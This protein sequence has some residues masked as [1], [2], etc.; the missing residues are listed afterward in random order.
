M[1]DFNLKTTT[2]I[3]I[4]ARHVYIAQL[5]GTIVGTYLSKFS[6]TEIQNA[7]QADESAVKESTALA[8][9]RALQGYKISPKHLYTAFPGKDVLIRHFQIPKIPRGEWD[10][11]IKFEAKK[12]IPF[13]I[14]ELLW[15]YHVVLHKSKDAKMDVTFVAVKNVVAQRYLS[16]FEQAG[17]KPAVLEPA[18]FSL[19]RLLTLSNQLEKDK[20]TMIVDVDYGLTDINIV[21]DKICYLTRDATL[22]LL[23]EELIFDA[24]LNEIRMSLDYYEKLFPGET[25]NKILLCGEVDLKDWDRRLAEESQ[26]T[27][28]KVNFTKAV[29]LK[30]AA[31]PL[32]MSVAIGLILR[33]LSVGLAEV[34][35]LQDRAVKPKPMMI[36]KEAI[37]LTPKSRQAILRAV[38]FSCIGLLILH[39][40]MF[41]LIGQ[42]KKKL[43]SLI[44]LR[45]QI[46]LPLGSVDYEKLKDIRQD[47]QNRLSPL[48]LIIDKR[49]FWTDKFNEIPKEIP[50]GVWLTNLFFSDEVAKKNKVERS[51]IIEGIAYH[52]DPVQEIGIV[53]KFVSDLKENEIFFQGLEEIKLD[54]MASIELQTMPVKK[55]VITCT[56]K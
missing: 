48:E 39:L 55:F 30:K 3:Y 22:P 5:K 12:Y 54:S 15:D 38:I 28:E 2:G 9:R 17:L 21:K 44:A 36:Q 18:P 26:M 7:G 31:P 47:L 46:R 45:P 6:R 53:T 24:L 50:A 35:L 10:A 34:N 1:I 43:D 42:E 11:A 51:L 25:V 37:K 16:F 33:D 32:N 41:R 8:L 19:V 56:K 27:V 52:E 23:D 13:R 49:V 40:V 29:K 4:G 14:E 20:P